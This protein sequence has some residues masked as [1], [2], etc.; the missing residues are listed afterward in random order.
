MKT[1]ADYVSELI[2]KKGIDTDERGWQKQAALIIGISE[3]TMSAHVAGNA[4]TWS[5]RVA[6]RIAT[7]LGV[8]PVEVLHCAS[9]ERSKDDDVRKAWE[10]ARRK[11]GP[12]AAG[13]MLAV[14]LIGSPTPASASFHSAKNDTVYYVKRRKAA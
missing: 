3:P 9:M 13:V 12:A 14:A 7:E 10:A 2:E 4:V 6:Y 5:D 1:M 11:L 8:D